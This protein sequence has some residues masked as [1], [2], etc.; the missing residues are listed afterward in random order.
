VGKFD[1]ELEETI[2]DIANLVGGIGEITI[3]FST[4]DITGIIN[5]IATAINS[6][7]NLFIKQ[8]ANYIEPIYRNGKDRGNTGYD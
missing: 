4:G 5:G 8:A 2:N 6:I 1:T 7:I 3:G